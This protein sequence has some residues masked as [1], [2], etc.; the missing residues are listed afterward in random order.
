MMLIVSW[1]TLMIAISWLVAFIAS[2]VALDMAGKVAY[3][4]KRVALFWL[5]AAGT[6]M[7]MGIWAMHFIGMLAM[8]LPITVSHN[9]NLTAVSLLVAIFSSLISLHLTASAPQ[10]TRARLVLAA[11]T[12]G[13]GVV[14]MHY[15]GVA[16]IAVADGIHWNGWWVAVS[17]PVAF[18]ASGIAMWLAFSLR[19]RQR[20]FARLAAA[21]V[22]GAA[23]AAIQYIGFSPLAHYHGD[24][25]N[26]R[27][28]SVWVSA[29]SLL[30]LGAMLVISM[31]D[32]QWRA[33]RLTDSLRQANDQLARLAMHDA[34]TGLPNRMQLERELESCLHHARQH[35]QTFALMY[36]DLDG[37]KIVNDAWGHYLGDQLLAGVTTRLRE[38]LGPG[39]TLARIGGDEFVLL[40]RD[41]G[42]EQAA[43]LADKLVQA[44]EQPFHQ[45]GYTLRVTLSVGI[46]LFPRDGATSHDLRLNADTAMYSIKQTGRNGWIFYSPSFSHHGNH[47]P[48]LLQALPKALALN[49]FRL[50]YQPKYR[51]PNGPIHG[52]EALI[53]WQH[54]QKG[55]LLPDKFLPMAEKTGLIIAI[56]EWVINEA[57]R[58]LQVWHQ[59]GQVHWTVA[60]NISPVQFDQHNLVSV[61]SDAL[62]KYQ[63]PPYM[64]TLEITES[65]AMRNLEKSLNILHELDRLGVKVSIDDFGTGYSNL[66]SLRRLPARELKIDRTFVKDL[67]LHNKNAVVVTTIIEM[68][69]SMNLE[70][71]A[72][73]VETPEQ[74]ELLT[75]LG[76][77]S[78]QGF[79]LAPPMPPDHINEQ[80]ALPR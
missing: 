64:L 71:V 26:Q 32:A 17:I 54:P 27:E 57:C 72:E 70:V 46:S 4:E 16:A 43:A 58:Q 21:L 37:F 48:E 61:I 22:I 18:V 3:C 10:L 53:R 36:M 77:Y 14:C 39:M 40:M 75:R 8:H 41:C 76:C 47:Q 28:L 38:Y 9:L 35:R 79:L 50:W 63:I 44:I 68:A 30:I 66:L 12:F 25:V 62:A 51:P 52:F 2:F 56:G 60:I 67:L 34:L 24:S 80:L 5:T 11:Q 73:G 15:T 19:L 1:D 74:Q 65:V 59:Q 33:S 45:S 29:I 20:L 13:G 6:A 69:R 31:L 23:I 7:G 49:Q 42:E 78:L 55:L